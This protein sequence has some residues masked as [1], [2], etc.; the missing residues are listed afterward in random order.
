MDASH[1]NHRLSTPAVYKSFLAASDAEKFPELPAGHRWQMGTN[2]AER[3]HAAE[4]S[5]AHWMDGDM[6]LHGL[7]VIGYWKGCF[8]PWRDDDAMM[9]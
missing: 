4:P 5:R 2:A 9:L 3:A 6:V 1:P 7:G 8:Q